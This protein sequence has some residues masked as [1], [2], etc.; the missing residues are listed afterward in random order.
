[1]AASQEIAD[2]ARERFRKVGI[3]AQVPPLV[4]VLAGLSQLRVESISVNVV[5]NSPLS[6][7]LSAFDSLRTGLGRSVWSEHVVDVK[8]LDSPFLLSWK[9]KELLAQDTLSGDSDCIYLYL[10]HDQA[11]SQENLDYFLQFSPALSK[12]GLAPGFLRIEWSAQ[13]GAFVSTDQKHKVDL[14]VSTSK[15]IGGLLW[16]DMPNPYYGLA[17]MTHER[18]VSHLVAPSASE[19]ES[20]S[21]IDWGIT[22]RAAMC[23]RFDGLLGVSKITGQ[24]WRACTP[25]AFDISTLRPLG[26]C[27]AWHLSNRYASKGRFGVRRGFGSLQVDDLFAPLPGGGAFGAREDDWKS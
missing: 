19:A 7:D 25:V 23:D 22:E 9:Y 2:L 14:G 10:E 8:E 3:P 18:A 24:T 4:S 15:A 12:W 27:Q 11:F 5:T 26:G 20:R 6:F 17:V 21:V 1:M 13:K 16:V